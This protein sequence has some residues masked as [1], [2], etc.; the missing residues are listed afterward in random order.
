MTHGLKDTG[1]EAITKYFWTGEISRP[2]SV[3]VGLF[4]DM[5]DNLSDSDDIGDITTEPQGASYS[6]VSLNFGTSDMSTVD[7]GT[8]WSV[9]FANRA[10]GT[11]DSSRIVDSYFVAMS[12]QSEDK[13]DSSANL[14]LLFTAPLDSDYNLSNYSSPT[15][16]NGGLI[17]N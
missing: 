3:S 9:E 11:S 1:E 10:F 13:G 4:N 16:S 17:A 12:F 15:L 5:V 14:H 8:D 7:S 6:R 2:S